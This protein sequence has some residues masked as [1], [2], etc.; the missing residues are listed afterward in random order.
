[1]SRRLR[2]LWLVAL[3]LNATAPVTAPAQPDHGTGAVTT[4]HDANALTGRIRAY[5]RGAGSWVGSGSAPANAR[6]MSFNAP[7]N[8]HVGLPAPRSLLNVLHS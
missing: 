4:V 1:M 3:G 5:H 2:L 8:L 6:L 7:A